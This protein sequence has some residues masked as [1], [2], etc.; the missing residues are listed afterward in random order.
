MAVNLAS[1]STA[2]TTTQNRLNNSNH[3]L[4]ISNSKDEIKV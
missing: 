3:K 2:A 4:Q 1:I